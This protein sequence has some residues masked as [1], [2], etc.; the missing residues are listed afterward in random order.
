MTV[1]GRDEGVRNDEICNGNGIIG[2]GLHG[3]VLHI[4]YWSAESGQLIRLNI[5]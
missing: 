2:S 5:K 1:L 3:L 4:K